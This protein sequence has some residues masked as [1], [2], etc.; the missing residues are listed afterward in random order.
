MILTRDPVDAPSTPTPA[1]ARIAQGV[2]A[3]L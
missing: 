2:V 1:G 3:L